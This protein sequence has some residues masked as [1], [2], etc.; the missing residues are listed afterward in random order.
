MIY[1]RTP[2][3]S[4][5]PLQKS[6]CM[7]FCRLHKTHQDPILTLNGSPIHVVEKNKIFGVM[8]D[9]K[10]SSI[11]NIR[12][13]NENCTRALNLLA[14][15]SLAITALQSRPTNPILHL[16]RSLIRSKFALKE[17]FHAI[18]FETLNYWSKSCV[19]CS[20]CWQI[21]IILR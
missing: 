1:I 5:F 7:H 12:H 15:A 20:V 14:Y 19:Q 4:N 16:Y 3:A 8:F 17:T 10:L 11:R 2:T 21:N 18:L 9:R 6:V 13:I